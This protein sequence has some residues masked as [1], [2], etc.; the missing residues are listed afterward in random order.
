ME[1][2]FTLIDEAV[3]PR[4]EHF[5]YFMNRVK[6]RYTITAKVDITPFLE[7]VSANRLRFY[8]S[9]LYAVLTAVNDNQEFRMALDEQGRP[10]FWNFLNP[11][12][13][14]F[15]E[16]DHTFS[17]LWSP[18][19][20][21]FGTFYNSILEDMADY[22]HLKGIKIKPDCPPNFCPVSCLPWLHYESCSQDTFEPSSFLFPV[23]RFGQ[24]KKE[25]ERTLLPLSVFVHHA[26]AD[27][28]HTCKLIKD[29]EDMANKL[30]EKTAAFSSL[31][32]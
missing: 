18:Y 19:S 2:R 32:P 15:H 21:D 12:Y 27:G 31:L 14:I 30:G 7:F 10:G 5:D 9:F 4:K 25:G 22:R 26:A 28:Y 16:D 8:P 20:R 11:G 6:C 29:I 24:Y 1:P 23:V 17:D 3:W 13:T